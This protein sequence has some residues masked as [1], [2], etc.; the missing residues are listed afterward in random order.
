MVEGTPS[1]EASPDEPLGD[2]EVGDLQENV[3]GNRGKPGRSA[4]TLVRLMWAADNDQGMVC[5]P[6]DVLVLAS[7]LLNMNGVIERAKLGAEV[8]DELY[9]DLQAQYDELLEDVKGEPV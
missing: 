8:A 1:E 7:T 3:E 6:V 9:A 5:S 2:S 4:D